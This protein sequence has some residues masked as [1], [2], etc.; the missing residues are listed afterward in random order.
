MAHERIQAIVGT[1]LVDPRFRRGLLERRS[2][3]LDGY[4]L[5][6]EEA[7]AV[8]SIEANTLEAFACELDRWILTMGCEE[9][10][11]QGPPES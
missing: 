5:T 6:E 8:S 4:G 11:D 9:A 10:G 2:G 7:K 1:A 3:V